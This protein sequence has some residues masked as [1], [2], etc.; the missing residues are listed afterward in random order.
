MCLQSS[1]GFVQPGW[2]P[3]F[4]WGRT[5]RLADAAP[6]RSLARD[7][8]VT[9]WQTAT[10]RRDF[11]AGQDDAASERQGDAALPG[12]VVLR[13][14]EPVAV[15]LVH[16]VA[17]LRADT[18]APEPILE[19]RAEVAGELG[20]A[21]VGPKLMDADGAGAAD[22][23]GDHR[24]RAGAGGIAQHEVGVVGELVELAAPR[25]RGAADA[26]LRPAAAG[27]N[28]HVLVQPRCRVDGADP[29]EPP[30]GGAGLVEMGGARQ[31]PEPTAQG[32]AVIGGAG[33]GLQRC[34]PRGCGYLCVEH[35]RCEGRDD[36]RGDEGDGTGQHGFPPR[37]E[38]RS[39]EH[40]SELQSLAYLVCRLLLEKKKKKERQIL[41]R[42]Y[43]QIVSLRNDL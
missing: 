36:D 39:E 43:K 4:G 21:A 7:C 10:G 30:V 16:E 18:E 5:T 28:A 12:D 34:G 41:A 14:V 13:L 38:V 37:D 25:E 3:P 2:S 6:G 11:R 15:E 32:D 26:V 31:A 35:R 42:H 23:I 29:A 40:T 22:E 27:A 17:T 19:P 20:P 1:R 33:H 9:V 8:D 24:A